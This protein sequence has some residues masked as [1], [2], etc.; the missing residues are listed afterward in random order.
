LIDRY[1]SRFRELPVAAAG[2]APLPEKISRGVENLDAI[3][4][5][6]RDVDAARASIDRHGLRE[7]EL[8]IARAARAEAEEVGGAYCLREGEIGGNAAS[9]EK[10]EEA[11]RRFHDT[12]GGL[13][14]I[15]A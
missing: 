15:D 1:A 5:G 3:V 4:V 6:I 13:E 11:E 9:D 12:C 2:R 14:T 10:G 7:V 8:P